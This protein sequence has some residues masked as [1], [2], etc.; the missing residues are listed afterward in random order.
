MPASMPSERR[1]TRQP[2]RPFVPLDHSERASLVAVR[3]ESDPRRKMELYGKHLALSAP[4]HV[5][6]QL[7]ILDA[8]A[9]GPDAAQLWAQL[10]AE[11][12]DGTKLFA[13]AL[14]RDGHLRPGVTTSEARDVLWTY[15]SA[16]LYRLLVIERAWSAN[17]YFRWV[18][19]ALT[20]AL[21]L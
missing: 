18:A 16:E 4:R 20:A 5:P 6:F 9:N 1:T 13:D 19:A 12:L 7:I 3:D 11:R 17:R 15:N 14:A 21:L 2:T 8:A 10:Q